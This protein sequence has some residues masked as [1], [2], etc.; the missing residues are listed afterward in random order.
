M[1]LAKRCNGCRIACR[2]RRARPR[3]WSRS[4]PAPV[5]DTW[6]EKVRPSPLGARTGSNA[7]RL[8]SFGLS[9]LPGSGHKLRIAP[10]AGTPCHGLGRRA[11]DRQG[12]ANPRFPAGRIFERVDAGCPKKMVGRR[13]SPGYEPEL[14]SGF[15]ISALR[16]ARSSSTPLCARNCAISLS[17]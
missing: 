12:S 15:A 5:P 13:H 1:T 4:W 6:L 9:E 2:N 16:R 11:K 14:F 3:P 17:V 7:T 8:L 10:C